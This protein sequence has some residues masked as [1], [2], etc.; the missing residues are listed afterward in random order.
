MGSGYTRSFRERLITTPL[1][2]VAGGRV[3]RKGQGD[4]V[5]VN[6]DVVNAAIHVALFVHGVVISSVQV[7]FAIGRVIYQNVL[8]DRHF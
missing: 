8:G 1:V 6:F 3:V 2:V 7:R 4:A 5:V